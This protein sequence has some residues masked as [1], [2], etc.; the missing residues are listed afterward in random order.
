M[1]APTAPRVVSGLLVV[2]AL[3]GAGFALWAWKGA[4]PDIHP[5][6]HPVDHGPGFR[7]V[8]AQS[9][10]TF[11]MNFL[12]D[13]QGEKFKINLYDHGSGVAVADFDG[14]GYEDVYLVNQLGANA[15]YRNKGDGTFE[16]VTAR[17]GVGLGDR[18]CVGAVFADYDN[19]GRQD[20]FVTST[21]GGNV[22][23]RNMGDGTFKDVTK[24]AGLSHVGH[25]QMGIFFDYDNDGYLDLLLLQTAKWTADLST[26][27]PRYYAGKESYTQ[28]AASEKE[29][30]L[31]YRNN[32]DGTFTE[33]G[34]KAGLRGQGWA[35]DAAVFDYDGDGRLDVLI[36]SMFGRS[37]LYRNNGDG[38]FTDVTQQVLGKTSWGGM[39]AKAFDFDND[40]KLDLYIVDMHSDMWT[41]F[42]VD[43]KRIEEKKKYPHLSGAGYN[44]IPE[45]LAKVR[46]KDLGDLVNVKYDEVVFGN[47]FYKNLGG[48]R[49]EEISDRAG[50]ETFWPWGIAVGDFDNDGYEDVFEPAGMGYPFFYWPNYLLM[51]NGDGTFINRAERYG[52]EPPAEKFFI[53]KKA[54]KKPSARSSR[55]AAVADFD[56]DGRLDIIVNNFNDAPYYFKNGLPRRNYVAFRLTGTRSNRDAVGATVTLHMGKEVM[57]RQVHA[58]GGYLAQSSRVL[59]FGLG[60]RKTI[61]RAEVRWPSGRR[62]TIERPEM[63]KLYLITEP[64]DENKAPR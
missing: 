24:E 6:D 13:E 51:N 9:G 15:L 25:S 17:A 57:I 49:F 38:T 63:N 16:D 28:T 48:G 59:H 56:N 29:Y 2:A 39:G 8:L 54:P 52:V 1:S 45:A 21:R 23:F 7:N 4:P 22:L 20:L 64:K 11:H 35:A 10:I 37:Q 14:D 31:L 46:E 62:Q 3:A 19:D 61:D 5:V 18:I 26:E 55:A 12:P 58:A 47:V 42:D 40:G 44:Q 27:S 30:N 34:E 60:D 50:L 41:D 36:T 53:E 32:G 43:P 33:V